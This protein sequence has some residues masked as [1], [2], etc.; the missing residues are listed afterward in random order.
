[1]KA[2]VIVDR[3][4]N[5]GKDGGLLVHLPKDLKYFKEKTTGKVIVIGRKTLESFPKK[6]PLPN[7]TNIVLTNNENY[8]NEDC[9]ICVGVDA[10]KEELKKY[11]TDDV[12]VAGGEM[13]Y[14]LL[15]PCC[16]EVYVTKIDAAFEADKSFPNLDDDPN[17]VMVSQSE[18]VEDK[19]YQFKFLKYEKI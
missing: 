2:I 7:R 10:L 11:N 3:N 13:I 15:L 6:R 17:Y 8:K 16:D 19:G 18:V 4:W 9:T 5:I 12:F 14:R 1:M